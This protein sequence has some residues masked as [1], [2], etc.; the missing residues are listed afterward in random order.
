[1]KMLVGLAVALLSGLGIGGGGLLVI[2]LVFFENA[3]QI[4][5]Q[6]IN[7]LFFVVSSAVA[8]AVH[9]FKRKIPWKYVLF[10]SVFG[11]GGAALGSVITMNAE[12]VIIR[13]LFGLMLA[14]S[15]TVSLLKK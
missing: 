9:A 13:K 5:A 11:I 6:G 14:V 1:M 8:L 10:L 2:Y 3:E 7:L 12:P 4:G 15:G